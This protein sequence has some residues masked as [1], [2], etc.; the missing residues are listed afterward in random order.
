MVSAMIRA[1]C[2][3]DQRV[4]VVLRH[5]VQPNAGV[6][7]GKLRD[8]IRCL[9]GEEIKE[10]PLPLLE[11]RGRP[12]DRDRHLHGPIEGVLVETSSLVG[13]SSDDH[14][15]NSGATAATGGVATT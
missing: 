9:Y 11:V 7:D 14:R 4:G 5:F 2:M 3:E 6:A 1:G 15:A 8:E 12:H 13:R 10:G